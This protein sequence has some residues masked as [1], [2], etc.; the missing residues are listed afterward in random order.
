MAVEKEPLSSSSVYQTQLPK[1]PSSSLQTNIVC[2]VLH[3]FR[4]ELGLFDE[5][6]EVFG[7]YSS[8]VDLVR[9]YPNQA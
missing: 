1:P 8:L 4:E 6:A 9:S 5:P 3:L 2:V 7:A